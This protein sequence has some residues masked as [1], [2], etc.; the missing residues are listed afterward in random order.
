MWQLI[1]DTQIDNT[2]FDVIAKYYDPT[3]DL[4]L[5]RRFTNCIQVNGVVFWS[6]PFDKLRDPKEFPPIK[7]TDHGFRPTHWMLIPEGPV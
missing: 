5:N 1:D 7:L 2:I 3:L 6:N 4:F